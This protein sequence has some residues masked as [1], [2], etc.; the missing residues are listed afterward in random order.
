MSLEEFSPPWLKAKVEQRLAFLIEHGALD[1]A[2]E[3]GAPFIMTFLDEGDPDM[4]AAERERWERTCDG[5]GRYIPGD[6]E[7]YTGH[8]KRDIEEVQVLMAFGVCGECK[9]AY[10]QKGNDE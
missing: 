1:V 10:D 3:S 5:C 6:G 7:F 2:R 4:T 9:A 8:I